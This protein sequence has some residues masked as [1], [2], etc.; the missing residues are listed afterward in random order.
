M[1]ILDEINETKKE[2]VNKLRQEFT[3]SRFTD[4]EFFDK[5]RIEFRKSLE[6]EKKISIIAEIKKASPS[7]GIILEDF[8]HIKI[9]DAYMN[10]GANAISVLTDVNY[11]KGSI[12]FLNDIAKIKTVPLL[13]KD[14]IIDEYQVYEAKANGADAILLI[15]ESLSKNQINELTAVAKETDLDVLLELHSV[16]QIEKIDFEQNKIIGINNRDLNSFQVDLNSVNIISKFIPNDNLLV[17]ES[18]IKTKKDIDFIKK[19]RAEAILIGEH[20]MSSKNIEES[21]KQLS[22]WCCYES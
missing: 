17:A 6:D 18:G 7:N 8:N 19:T 15:T 10:N 16:D 2:E 11:F 4:S 12:N 9:A 5:N 1:N 3:Y 14:F 22:E 20:L 21:L 13:R